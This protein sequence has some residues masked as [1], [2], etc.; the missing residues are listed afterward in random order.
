M[1]N[2]GKAEYNVLRTTAGVAF[3]VID[4]PEAEL[5]RLLDQPEE[6]LWR[7]LHRPVKIAHGSLMIEGELQLSGGVGLVAY[8]RYRP[9]DSWKS[10][11][12]L[13]RRS[14]A[15]AAWHLG[16]R[17]L[18]CGI[19]TPRPLAMCR[20]RGPWFRQASYLA[21]EWIEAAENLHLYG[22]RLADRPSDLRLRSAARCAESLGRLVG[23]M[24]AL[25]V[26]HRDL[27][28]ANLLV[29]ERG[30]QI[31]AYLV[32]LDGV[33]FCRRLGFRRRAA[34][35]ARLAAGM[36]AHPWVTRTTYRRFLRAYLQQ[37]PPGTVAWKTLWRQVAARSRRIAQGQLR[38]GEQ[39][40]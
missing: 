27:K 2:M 23:R 30:D 21:T 6:L 33:R 31:T 1:G 29:A 36:T 25:H 16:Y 18:A 17:L 35:L 20:P 19:P 4:L 12:G 32:D 11:L 34:N 26:A 22:W 28:A 3:G 15:E 9:R 7:N 37:H 10:L 39:V 14:R 5:K 13:F 40:L 24:H 38:R 8:K